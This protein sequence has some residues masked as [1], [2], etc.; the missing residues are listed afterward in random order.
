VLSG[1]GSQ[2]Q[3]DTDPLSEKAREIVSSMAAGDYDTPVASFDATM[4]VAMPAG[5]LQQAWE[6]LVAS[7]GPFVEVTSTRKEK[8]AGYDIVFVTCK[9]EKT[10]M[11]IKVV[12]DSGGLV[13]GL[14]F[15]PSQGSTEYEAPSYVEKDSFTEKEVTVGGGEWKLPGTLTMPKGEGPFPG[16]VLVHGSGPNDRDET[17]GPNKPFR[18]LAWG[19]ASRG[20]AVLRYEK[21]TRE[22]QAKLTA[23][24]KDLTVKQETVDDALIAADLLIHQQGVD[25]KKVYVLG[26]SLGGMLVPRIAKEGPEIH[27]FVIM[28]GP[29]SPLEDLLLEQMIYIA[30]L[31]ETP[32]AEEQAQLDQLKAAVAKV[33]DPSLSA[34]TPQDSLPL[35]ASGTYWLDLRGYEPA[36]VLQGIKR[37]TL[38]L[39]GERDYQVTMVDFRG[40]QDALSGNGNVTFE[41]YPDLNHLFMTGEGK[42]TPA[43]YQQAGHVSEQVVDDIAKFVK[44]H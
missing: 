6:A 5:T 38:I 43:E 15:V 20:V 37:P 32:S 23:S 44:T 17:L 21:R 7:A 18:D 25:R 34:D 8:A 13:A 39:Q 28:A 35:G 40:W 19:L 26:H 1:C 14:F 31:K 36:R 24:V 27:G 9:F 4:K 22:Y 11:D 29:T 33:K 2:K 10:S 30:S 3:T 42:A 16:V 12:F 41:S